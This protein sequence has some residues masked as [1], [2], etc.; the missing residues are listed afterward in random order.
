MVLFIYLLASAKK[1]VGQQMSL[2]LTVYTLIHHYI[3]TLIKPT[4]PQSMGESLLPPQNC[5]I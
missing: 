2:L 1:C 3:H 5:D 4:I